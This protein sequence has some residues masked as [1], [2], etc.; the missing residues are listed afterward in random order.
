MKKE[1]LK[2]RLKEVRKQKM[3]FA[4]KGNQIKFFECLDEELE[5]M[6]QISKLK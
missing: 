6:R 3:H 2:E 4:E 5:L 1:I